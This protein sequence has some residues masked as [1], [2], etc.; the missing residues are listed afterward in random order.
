MT[1]YPNAQRVTPSIRRGFDGNIYLDFGTHG[2]VVMSDADAITL[3]ANLSAIADHTKRSCLP[4]RQA[5]N[6]A[7]SL[8]ENR[9]DF[10][11]ED[12]STGL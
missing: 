8:S 4:P 10:N 12:G 2:F 6:E 7:P 3:A 11:K 1:M 5:L 9:T